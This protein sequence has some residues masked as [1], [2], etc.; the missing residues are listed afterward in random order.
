MMKNLKVG[1]IIT[2]S[3]CED[4]KFVH[5]IILHLS[6][7]YRNYALIGV[8]KNFSNQKFG[9]ESVSNLQFLYNPFYLNLKS[10]DANTVKIQ[11]NM[12]NLSEIDAITPELAAVNDLYFKD[13]FIRRLNLSE[14]SNYGYE[15]FA[16]IHAVVSFSRHHLGLPEISSEAIHAFWRD[17]A[18]ASNASNQVETDLKLSSGIKIIPK[19]MKPKPGDVFAI[20]LEDNCFSAGVILH[21]S[22]RWKNTVLCGFL[23]V[24]PVSNLK[25]DAIPD[26]LEFVEKPFYVYI[27]PLTSGEWPIIGSIDSQIVDQLIPRMIVG[28]SIFLKD[29]YLGNVPTE[30]I[31]DY[32]RITTITD[33]GARYLLRNHF[34]FPKRDPILI[35]KVQAQVAAK[36]KAK[37][38][39]ALPESDFWLL[40]ESCYPEQ[41]TWSD[42]HSRL[43]TGDDSGTEDLLKGQSLFLKKLRKALSK[44]TKEQL[45]AFDR[46]LERKLYDIDRQD[47]QEHTDGSDDGFLYARGFIVSMGREYYELVSADPSKAFPDLEFEEFCYFSKN[48]YEEKYGSMPA[49]TISRES[50]SNKAGWKEQ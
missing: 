28:W 1:D 19:K 11:L 48:L 20:P 23:N 22:K 38:I 15:S 8:L 41:K 5:A 35:A 27:S 26:S 18:P 24:A 40:L 39:P 21:V 17:S 29:E 50:T 37:L 45:L 44:Y 2:I 16:N 7:R 13:E 25:L 43:L 31:S 42:A 6:K 14:L 47:I 33:S 49:S 46:T 30:A 10:I 34:G 4:L 32:P 12:G 36:A 3:L 9:T